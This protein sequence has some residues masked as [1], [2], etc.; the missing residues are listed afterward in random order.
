MAPEQ[1]RGQSHRVGPATDVYG[2]GAIL[3]ELLT[4]PPPFRAET[5]WDTAAQVITQ[6]PVP[7][8]RVRPE[9]PQ[10][11]E[12]ICLKCL[13]KEPAER[14][15]SAEALADDPHGFLSA[16]AAVPTSLPPPPPRRRRRLPAVIGGAGIAALFCLLVV[17]VTFL[18]RPAPPGT[19]SWEI[20]PP[21]GP[22]DEVFS[23]IAFPTRMAGFVAGRRGVYRTTDGGRSWQQTYTAPA[24]QPV[25][26]LRFQDERTGWLG[27]DRL[28]QTTDGGTTWE[29]VP[30]P[31][32][33]RAV[34]ALASGD[35]WLLAGG[36]AGQPDGDLVLFRKRG[37]T[38]PW[39]KLDPAAAGYWGGAGE[40]YRRWLPGDVVIRG[41]REAL[42]ALFDGYEERGVLLRTTDGGDSWAP[43]L[44]VENDLYRIGFLDG[45]R[46]WLAGSR[47]SL[48]KTADGGKTWAPQSNPGDVTP[49]CL[50]FAPQGQGFGL[51]PLWQGKVLQTATGD[52][53][54]AEQ[55]DVG[56]STPAAAVVDGGCAYLLGSDGRIARYLDPGAPAGS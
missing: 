8:S 16:P 29:Q 39:E 25:Y 53:W 43:V 9:V 32:Q 22:A 4:G 5:A 17:G 11:L 50:E 46:G 56:Y 45:Q 52:D 27:T 15:P 21:V 12:D 14:Y 48:W 33:V 40:P 54:R 1:A 24:P 10:P 18:R 51:A 2:L 36:A 19:P 49:S 13:R 26:F 34:R 38:A 41:P 42:A 6:E 47:G 20:L 23:R 30:L 7:P 35:G 44:A 31:E 3:Y 28:E 37:A 55:V